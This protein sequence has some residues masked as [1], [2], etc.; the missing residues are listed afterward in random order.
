MTRRSVDDHQ[1]ATARWL[2]YGALALLTI[3]IFVLV[4]SSE[5]L[6]PVL[7]IVSM[8]LIIVGR[9]KERRRRSKHKKKS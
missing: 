9:S 4:L 2:D 5:R 6:I 3:W 8:T 7:G 1:K